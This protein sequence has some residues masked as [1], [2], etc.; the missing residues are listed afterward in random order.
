MLVAVMHLPFMIQYTLWI[1]NNKYDMISN[2][3][4]GG[5]HEY[6]AN[7]RTRSR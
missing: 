1:T 2:S 5:F 4:Y 3:C 7:Y 6:K